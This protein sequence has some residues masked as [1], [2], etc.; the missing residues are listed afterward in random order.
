MVLSFFGR[1]NAGDPHSNLFVGLRTFR[2][3][4]RLISFR[5]FGEVGL[6]DVVGAGICRVSVLLEVDVDRFAL[7][8]TWAGLE[9]ILVTKLFFFGTQVEDVGEVLLG[10]EL[11][12]DSVG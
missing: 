6:W 8:L 12:E 11:G 7:P 9:Q 5:S 2:S 10:G 4:S 1:Q 3:T